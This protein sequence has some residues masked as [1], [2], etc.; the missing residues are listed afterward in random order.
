[1][2]CCSELDFFNTSN[3]NVLPVP[4]KQFLFMLGLLL[5]W[6]RLSAMA[7]YFS[8][9]YMSDYSHSLEMLDMY[10]ISNIN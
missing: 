10:D 2:Q 3:L 9:S 7:I 8:N 6:F 1:M 5:H 4:N